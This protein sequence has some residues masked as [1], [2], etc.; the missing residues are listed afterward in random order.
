VNARKRR[1]AA[2]DYAR[3][4]RARARPL[5]RFV[6]T[7]YRQDAHVKS[8]VEKLVWDLKSAPTLSPTRAVNARPSL[9]RRGW[10][11]CHARPHADRPLD[12]VVKNVRVV[13]PTTPAVRDAGRRRERRPDRAGAPEIAVADAQ[14]RLRRARPLA[15]PG[16]VD[17]HTHVGI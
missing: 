6:R 12:L 2:F 11:W 15:F 8:I 7:A 16:V 9:D 1:V 4:S 5:D 14:R 10:R 3:G 17:A 13:R